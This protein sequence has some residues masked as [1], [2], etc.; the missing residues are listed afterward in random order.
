MKFMKAPL[1]AFRNRDEMNLDEAIDIRRTFPSVVTSERFRKRY[2]CN[3][4]ELYGF[5]CGAYVKG[6]DEGVLENKS[7]KESKK[8]ELGR[9]WGVRFGL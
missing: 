4:E 2:F 9:R 1:Q 8:G 5:L 7:M 6:W 3:C